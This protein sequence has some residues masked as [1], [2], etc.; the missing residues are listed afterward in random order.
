M[1]ETR[2]NLEIV[3]NALTDTPQSKAELVE[4]TGLSWTAVRGGIKNLRKHPDTPV[5]FSDIM[6]GYWRDAS[7][8]APAAIASRGHTARWKREPAGVE[9]RATA[10]EHQIPRVGSRARELWD[11][12]SDRPQ[13]AQEL[14]EA[15]KCTVAQ[16]RSLLEVL[17]H[18]GLPVW[19]SPSSGGFW[20]DEDF[21]NVPE[22]GEFG[23]RAG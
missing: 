9:P 15:L 21:H 10:S 11:R 12:L 14:A 5:F 2:L 3:W 13:S 23:G 18:K 1:S 17:R 19:H 4:R 7:A 6:R 20:K 22:R 16:V 8:K